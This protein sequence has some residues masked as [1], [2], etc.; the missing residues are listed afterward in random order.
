MISHL[1]RCAARWLAETPPDFSA[2]AR[3]AATARFHPG[4][5][6]QNLCRRPENIDVGENSHVRG[7][8]L[9]YW[10]GGEIRIGA[11]S[12]VGHGSRV[13]SR[14]SIRIGDYVLISHGVDIHDTNAHPL[15]WRQRRKDIE[16]VLGGRTAERPRD[17]AHA[18]VVIEDDVWIGAKAT[19][20]KGVRI[21]RGAVVAAGAIVTRDVPAF[22]LVAGNPARVIR[23]LPE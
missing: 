23:T 9:L 7:E 13:W 5:D 1:R 12:Y 8:L 3:I 16:A 20:L 10:E 22:S 17:I 15:D 14:D 19:V 6:V 11:W 2:V 18:P 4:A 21:G